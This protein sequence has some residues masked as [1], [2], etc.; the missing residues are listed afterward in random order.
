MGDVIG[1]LKALKGS[2]RVDAL[3]RDAESEY[4]LG[5]FCEPGYDLLLLAAIQRPSNGLVLRTDC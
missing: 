5:A 1:S 3:E 4:R 2:D